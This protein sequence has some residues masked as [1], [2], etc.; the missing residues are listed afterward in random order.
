MQYLHDYAEEL[1][2]QYRFDDAQKLAQWSQHDLY[3]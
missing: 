3:R 2:Q 1:Q